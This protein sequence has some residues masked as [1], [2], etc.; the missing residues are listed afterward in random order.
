MVNNDSAH[1]LEVT[2]SKVSTAYAP[3]PNLIRAQKLS[4][5]TDLG[6]EV[7]KKYNIL[8]HSSWHFKPPVTTFTMRAIEPPS[9]ADVFG[10]NTLMVPNESIVPDQSDYI[11]LSETNCRA[12]QVVVI[13]DDKA[14]DG[15]IV[16]KAYKAREIKFV[17]G[18][19]VR[20][21]RVRGG[22]G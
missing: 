21:E 19:I 11:L 13:A 7:V 12:G 3:P 22:G 6:G 2:I 16:M 5:E 20:T 18:T 8:P 1:E 9:V 17:K 4:R 14:K 15:G 10:I